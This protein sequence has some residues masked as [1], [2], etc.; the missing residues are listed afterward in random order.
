MRKF[1]E[2][3]KMGHRASTEE[4]RSELQEALDA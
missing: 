2:D 4:E 1:A 3:T